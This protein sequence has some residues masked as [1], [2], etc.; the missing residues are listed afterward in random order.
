MSQDGTAVVLIVEDE[1]DLARS[2]EAILEASYTVRVATSGQEGLEKADDDVDVVLLDR[3]MPGM[4][5]D[6]MLAKLVERG[7]TAKVAMLTAVE[8]DR[9]IVDMPFDDYITKPV[10]HNG[11]LAL[12]DVLLKRATYDERSQEFFRLAAKKATLETAGEEDS[13]E[14][15]RITDRL[16]ELQQ[17]VDATL[18]EMSTEDAFIDIDPTT[19]LEN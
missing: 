19:Q 17:E 16:S 1:E 10:D 13:A 11:L 12:V 2:Y 7:I 15:R 8:P 4:S 6:E 18:D 14:Y 5:G 9:D 3:R